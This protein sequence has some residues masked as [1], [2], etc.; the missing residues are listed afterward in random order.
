MTTSVSS[1]RQ[2]IRDAVAGQIAADKISM[3]LVNSYT[4]RLCKMP[5]VQQCRLM[6]VEDLRN[7]PVY[8]IHFDQDEIVVMIERPS[9]DR[10][11][12]RIDY[13][14]PAMLAK[15]AQELA[16]AGIRMSV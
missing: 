15:L 4:I 3:V 8:I 11:V 1:P 6:H 2:A 16:L 7:Y 13:S 5:P 12:A 14:D 10:V 9:G